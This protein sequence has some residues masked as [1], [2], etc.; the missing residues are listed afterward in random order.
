MRSLATRGA[1]ALALLACGRASS[2]GS[3]PSDGSHAPLVAAT[4]ASGKDEVT[5]P[6]VATGS[7]PSSQLPGPKAPV[8]PPEVLSPLLANST[9]QPF[10]VSP[11]CSGY[12]F[13]TADAVDT[14]TVHVQRGWATRCKA[15]LEEARKTLAVDHPAFSSAKLEVAED[16]PKEGSRLAGSVMLWLP[17][18]QGSAVYSVEWTHTT[19]SLG[20]FCPYKP[21]RKMPTKGSAPANDA[22]YAVSLQRLYRIGYGLLRMNGFAPDVVSSVALTLEAALD[23]CASIARRG[24]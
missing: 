19:K 7:L 2:G 18:A 3:T 9:P 13:E 23:R 14:T 12:T 6:A 11:A 15:V 22:S 10:P 24:S 8:L 4:A 5:G 16:D 17:E 20:P 21:A 1:V